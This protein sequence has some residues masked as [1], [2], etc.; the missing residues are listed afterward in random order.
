MQ[1]LQGREGDTLTVHFCIK[2][3]QDNI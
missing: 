3:K 2:D 1:M